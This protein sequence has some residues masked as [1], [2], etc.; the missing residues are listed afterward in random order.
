MSELSKLR[1]T[2]NMK[3]ESDNNNAYSGD[4]QASIDYI[5]E[6][7]K[8]AGAG[9]Y[10]DDRPD[11]V[12]SYSLSD[13]RQEAAQKAAQESK[14]HMDN[15]SL[16]ELRKERNSSRWDYA[17]TA[18]STPF[19][20][21]KNKIVDKSEDKSVQIKADLNNAKKA[22][23]QADDIYNQK[24]EQEDERKSTE[25]AKIIEDNQLSSYLDDV[26]TSQ[27]TANA[28][29]S[30]ITSPDSLNAQKATQTRQLLEN[31]LKSIN[32]G[33]YNANDFINYY[34]AQKN[35]ETTKKVTDK[36]SSFSEKH[37][38]STEIARV[39]T[40]PLGAVSNVHNSL[41]SIATT[42]PMG[43]TNFLT[44]ARYGV[45]EGIEDRAADDNL[46][47]LQGAHIG[48]ILK[49]N[50]NNELEI[51]GNNFGNINSALY[52]NIDQSAEVVFDSLLL[53]GG[54]TGG[55]T[56]GAASLATQAGINAIFSSSTM[57]D[58]VTQ[59][60]LNNT[61]AK[62]AY[63]SGLKDA[64]INFG[65]EMAGGPLE[66]AGYEG[67]S[68][69][70]KILVS[71]VNE[72][73]EEVIGNWI[74]RISDELINGHS[75]EAQ[76]AYQELINQGYS[77]SDATKRLLKNMLAEDIFASLQAG[78]A[79]A[80]M[81]GSNIVSNNVAQTAAYYDEGKAL[82]QNP[83]VATDVVN[84]GLQSSTDG[85]A[86]QIASDL[87][88]NYNYDKQKFNN[89]KLGKLQ[90]LNSIEGGNSYLSEAVSNE[91]NAEELSTIYNKA[92]NGA[93]INKREA[94][95]FV[96]SDFVKNI[97]AENN[98]EAKNNVELAKKAVSVISSIG[99]SVN[100]IQTKSPTLSEQSKQAA[101]NF[102]QK[103]FNQGTAVQTKQGEKVNITTIAQTG[104]SVLF[105]T[106]DN[107]II[108]AND[109]NWNDDQREML[110]NS[111]K[112]YSPNI[113]MN[114]INGYD[115]DNG[116]LSQYN[117][118]FNTYLRLVGTE[119]YTAEDAA[120]KLSDMGMPF[121]DIEAARFEEAGKQFE[122]EINTIPQFKGQ[123]KRVAP[124]QT[125]SVADNDYDRAYEKATDKK[126]ADKLRKIL[127]GK[128][129]KG[130]TDLTS[131]A[132][133]FEKLQMNV[134]SKVAEDN[135][136]QVV[137]VNN[138]ETLGYGEKNGFRT[139]EGKIV[140]ALNNQGG[141]MTAYFGHE[142]CHDLEG[143][144][145]YS[146]LE[147]EVMKYL[148]KTYGDE[149]LQKRI[150][151]IMQS[152]NLS[153]QSAKAE[154]VANSCMTVF[155]ENFI[156]NFAKTHT[157]EARTIKDWFNRL[158]A[159]IRQAMDKVKK[160]VTEYRAISDDVAEVERIRDLFNAALSEKNSNG[161][162]NSIQ[163]KYS[164]KTIVDEN[165]KNYGKG[166]YLD[167]NI[168]DGLNESARKDKIVEYINA[169][170]GQGFYA[171]DKNGEPVLIEIPTSKK[172]K[173]KSGKKK[174]ANN[175]LIRKNNN[176]VVK[177]Q[178]LSLIDETIQL[179][180]YDSS[181]PSKY[182]HGWLDDNGKT[183]W[184]YYTVF[185]QEKNKTIWSATLN[186]ATNAN[187][188]KILYDI[189]PIKKVEPGV[190]SPATTISSIS[191]V[192][193]NVK[194]S[195]KNSDIDSEY[196]NA[197]EQKKE[198]IIQD[199]AMEWGAYSIDG[200]TP[201]KL[202]HGTQ[203]F[204]FTEFDLNKM[205][206]ER[207]IFLTDD[208]TMAKTYSGVYDAK[209]ISESKLSNY[210]NLSEKEIANALSKYNNET[211]QYKYYT[212]DNVNQMI[213]EINQKVEKLVKSVYSSYKEKQNYFA[214]Y[215]NL[216]EAFKHPDLSNE[217]TRHFIFW[218]LDN[219]LMS[220]NP[221]VKNLANEINSYKLNLVGEYYMYPFVAKEV[222]K[223]N[224]IIVAVNSDGAQRAE[225]LRKDNALKKLMKL[226][227]ASLGN[228]SLYAKLNNPFVI[229]V[230]GGYWNKIYTALEPSEK[231][232]GEHTTREVAEFA[233]KQGYDGVVFK[234]IIDNG[235]N[236]KTKSDVADNV[237]VVFDNKMVKSADTVTYD[238]NGN[239]IP[240]SERFTDK[241]DLRFSVKQPVEETKDL[242]AIHNT[243]EEKLLKSLQLGGLPSPSIAIMKAENTR[244]NND[245][246][247][248]S[249]VFDKST[250]DPQ[251]NTAN[252]VYSSDAYTPIT[253]RAEHKLNEDKAWDVY[254]KIR[255]LSKQKL[256]YNLNPS[257]FHPDN[258]K[259]S[260]DSAG[261]INELVDSYKNDYAFKE[262]YLADTA[263]PIKNVVEKEVKTTVSK[264]DTD[265]FDYFND[266]I[267]NVLDEIKSRPLIPSKNWVSDYDTQVVNAITDYFKELIPGI[268]SENIEN[269]FNNSDKFS[270]PMQRKKYALA[271]TRYLENGSTTVKTEQDNEATHK[272]IDEKI[273][274]DDYEQWLY[275]L[276]DGVVEKKGISKGNGSYNESGNRKSWENLYW[277]Y[278]LENIVKAMNAQNAQGGNF[279]VSNIIGGSAYNYGSIDEIRSDKSR[280]QSVDT[281]Q[282]EKLRDNLYNRFREIS[283]SM[284]KHDN[285]FA[286]ADVIVEGV[287][288]TKT[289]SGLANYLKTELKGWANYSDMAVDD[290]WSLVNDIR[291]LPTEY[292]EAKPQRAVYFNEVYNAVIPD[293]SSDTLKNALANAG[294][295]YSEYKAGDND[296]RAEVL[297][298]MDS[299]KFSDKVS[300]DDVF[301]D[302]FD[303]DDEDDIIALTEDL[304]EMIRLSGQNARQISTSELSNA[305]EQ[306]GLYKVFEADNAETQ[307]TAAALRK[308]Y[309]SKYN[310][311]LLSAQLSSLY[312][313]MYNNSDIDYDYIWQRAKET[314][315]N[316]ASGKNYVDDSVYRE[317][318]DVRRYIRGQVLK[319]S[320][321]TVNDFGAE[322]FVDF[323]KQ[324]RGK[325]RL[326]T[327]YGVS[328]DSLYKELHDMSDYY[329]PEVNEDGQ[330]VVGNEQAE[331][332]QMLDF[333][334]AT[335]KVY[336]N[337]AEEEAEDSGMTIDQYTNV[338]ATDILYRFTM[339]EPVVKSYESTQNE[340]RMKEL[341]SSYQSKMQDLENKYKEEY[342][343][344]Y[345]QILAESDAKI[346]EL[347]KEIASLNDENDK[348]K[349]DAAL[350]KRSA[351]LKT[352]ALAKQK[353]HAK[354]VSKNATERRKASNLR[355]KIGNVGNTLKS[356]LLNP[357]DNSY[358]PEYL[359]NSITEVCTQINKSQMYWKNGNEKKAKPYLES[360]IAQYES[361]RNDSDFDY[362]D[363][364]DSEISLYLSELN[365]KIGN[366]QL[367]QL[368][369]NELNDIYEI[370]KSI[371][372]SLID[373]TKQIGRDTVISNYQSRKKIIN[374]VMN[375]QGMRNKVVGE[376]EFWTLNPMRFV[377]MMSDYD[378]NAELNRQFKEL[379]KGQR[380][381]YKVMYDLSN[382]LNK[383]QENK[384]EFK[385]F[386]HDK[387]ETN[388]ID[389]N[390]NKV[391]MTPAQI[392]Q[393][394]MTAQRQ[395]G[396]T[397]LMRGGINIYDIESLTKGKSGDGTVN[398]AVIVPHISVEDIN[399]LYDLLTDYDKSWISAAKQT[400]EDSK[401]FINETSLVL[402]HRKIAKG[403]N[404][405]PLEVD[406]EDRQNEISGLTFDATLEG[407]GALKAVNPN[408]GQRLIIR[409]LPM[410][411]DKH[412]SFVSSYAG[413]AIPIRNFKKIYGGTLSRKYDYNADNIYT[414][415][416]AI[417]KKWTTSKDKIGTN[418]VEQAIADLESR[419][420]VDRA[421]L[422]ARI[423]SLW[424]QYTLAG[425]ISVTLK[426]AASYPTAGAILSNYALN[427]AIKQE[428]AWK[429]TETLYNEID[430]HTGIH[431]IRRLGLSVQEI[432]E[433][434]QD[435]NAL[436]N[437]IPDKWQNVLPSNWIQAMDVR[438][439]ATLWIACKLEVEKN[440]PEIAK[441]SQ[442]YWDKVTELYEDVI[443][444]TQP[445]YDSLHRGEIQKNTNAALR[446]FN[447]FK[448]QT[449]QNAGLVYDSYG[450]W[451]YYR[452][453]GDKEKAK[454]ASKKFMRVVQTQTVAALTLTAMTLL[455]NVIKHKL[456]KYRDDDDKITWLSI[457]KASSND[458]LATLFTTVLPIGASELQ[459][460]YDSAKNIWNGQR[461]FDI[462]QF[463]AVTAINDSFTSVLDLISL[464]KKFID[465]KATQ[466]QFEKVAMNLLGT[467]GG[468]SQIPV[469]NLYLILKGIIE[470]VKEFADN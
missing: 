120:I 316:I 112:A 354:E 352:K 455:A 104:D 353:A 9:K 80:A 224:G 196:E 144:A 200:E 330:S 174:K 11:T 58:S 409:G 263:E 468:I 152:Q 467:V 376:Y 279:L 346:A 171:T 16:D 49:V 202:Y 342:E 77:E 243:T 228:Y 195:V 145:A 461:G 88:E 64:L 304:R 242:I 339:I 431:Y 402:K 438:T 87:S 33:E 169:L 107:K 164:I 294:I 89:Y 103:Y 114:Y 413:L 401:N 92:A 229:D 44:T 108:N 14:E 136:I 272:L 2:L 186:V 151:G 100:D 429:D 251:A 149:N 203:S 351:T 350:A 278:N 265:L 211:T 445:N 150:D 430:S 133:D 18:V 148:A 414:V 59:Q 22:Y 327:E 37:P 448:T 306:I 4:S 297:N 426:Q 292:F 183:N 223:E 239:I 188:N 27:Q 253:V 26:Y 255:E 446:M 167:S 161:N 269:I 39:V 463:P 207:S 204:G 57:G 392:A 94:N 90:E 378:D 43:W 275:D 143:T 180:K 385:R 440:N 407:N 259:S 377:R 444:Y 176:S 122:R 301:D 71:G 70:G 442:A 205:D 31:K 396:L 54:I 403:N 381:S 48:N 441:G 66:W 129:K 465:G 42:K 469:K 333:F 460:F 290:I 300:N 236:G 375:S 81:T 286:V 451:M 209:K 30:T 231:T 423:Q 367:S 264:E 349:K 389:T 237:V 267:G 271:A 260:I 437:K 52:D 248:I 424:V 390:G 249:L 258:L 369:A 73:S 184:D 303:I 146:A 101:D 91:S 158:V 287:A 13:I 41:N 3:N 124:V 140:L 356:K 386:T 213:D 206:D 156:T 453:K 322:E 20:Q 177:L 63:K 126:N 125:K 291:A 379:E 435:S 447:M 162:K 155:D 83:S 315:A 154:I 358:V 324:A 393:V 299:I 95:T 55:I 411:L 153:E 261:G 123:T 391:I 246:G 131:G 215:Y 373:A 372:N 427:E 127:K 289:K 368:S 281:A 76:Q 240:P 394:Y 212:E 110:V 454:A 422:T 102:K 166:V 433:L 29:K 383:L 115:S 116:T 456:D 53:G 65:T 323:K 282:Y 230:K 93:T 138:T 309:D 75:S 142:L 406:S 254:S 15:S 247:N 305:A 82:N 419:R 218:E 337:G 420:E 191:K 221:D 5:Q 387:I 235:G 363:E 179:S 163:I 274:Q 399:A 325:M 466:A 298:S 321:N 436:V 217:Q 226:S 32:T 68:A 178:S 319:V 106:T 38:V 459:G 425:N 56:K 370:V 285:P 74:D 382:S 85:K 338:I 165:G 340:T 345:N 6:K 135:N 418:L 415:K 96:N 361:L 397:H 428:Q 137:F 374:E 198:K 28:D 416:A 24:K 326:S 262:L 307:N 69:L 332:E 313:Y 311:Q 268:S 86:F 105:N 355:R 384:K 257:S 439:T 51:M 216:D 365:K 227:G 421:K 190:K 117:S 347:D 210:N 1:K 197:K 329:F 214:S 159:R 194:Y 380:K 201:L 256:A 457:L 225:Y 310:K 360:L 250:V 400:F 168:F 464:A 50:D 99:A 320:E 266:T 344:R 182:S 46:I 220:Q 60:L 160:Y 388:L 34:N 111:A 450:E 79:G 343:E 40:S 341:Q 19:K 23:Y 119:G 443:E 170:A 357:T 359:I 371:K 302:I 187:G 312:E 17:K 245:F 328:I 8:N 362:K 295:N 141:L 238:N 334:E 109:I 241:E 172:F 308:S 244:G 199:L 36:V 147:S 234:N 130:T 462:V 458:V 232:A 113:A 317:N 7:L 404:Y 336:H 132:S 233:H 331:L 98:I 432:A 134:I 12:Y 175:D 67:K 61:D 72:A 449:L 395:Q 193:E 25:I 417:N 208:I 84:Q 366:K 364:Y 452:R 280:L 192:R 348:I 222:E 284:T 35:L 270:T 276:F 189:S 78:L 121:T 410:V 434:S 318:L 118:K 62:E 185:L 293:N 288:K 128:T 296:S 408:A 219:L 173:N 157:K 252:K 314:A 181:S 21:L 412:I 470:W 283:Q 47:Q 277:D 398:K 45:K 97:I 139:P 405:I 273:N 335:Q 10:T